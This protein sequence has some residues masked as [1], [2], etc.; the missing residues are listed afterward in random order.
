MAHRG[1]SGL[2]P[3]NTLSAFQMALDSD[4]VDSIELDV[5]LSKDGVPVII[6]DF[7]VKRTT[8]GSG[9]VKNKTLKELRRLD[10]GSWF[11]KDFKGEKIPTLEEVLILCKG[12]IK[13]NIELKTAN[14]FYDGYEKTI[15]DLI[16]RY[17]MESEVSITSF[18]HEVIRN[19]KTIPTRIKTGLIVDG[20]PVLLEEQL[21][22]C[23][24][25][26]LS[27]KYHY[28]SETLVKRMDALGIEIVA[29]TVNSEYGLN[30]LHNA[31]PHIQLCTNFPDKFKEMISEI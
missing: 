10:A 1:F 12:K 11:S 28:I 6:H 29:W 26:I 27:I 19:M 24:A 4:V 22:E 13:L 14:G 16:K 8:N 15:V 25:S 23:G 18:D 3:E 17:D 31:F 30:R 9:F 5:Q 21:K 2:A 7:T 20:N